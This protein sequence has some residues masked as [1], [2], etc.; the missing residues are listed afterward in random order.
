MKVYR[1]SRLPID[2]FDPLDASASVRRGGWRWNERDTALLYAGS[3]QALAILEVAA[4]PGWDQIRELVIAEIEVPDGSVVDLDTLG[5]VLPSN[6]SNRPAAPNAKRIGT[7]FL[8]AVGQATAAGQDLCG[9]RVPSVIS[10]T[11]FTVILDPQQCDRYRVSNRFVLA[12][13]WLAG[14]ST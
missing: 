3:V 2:Q 4:R 5:I 11:D 1:A 14:T 6:W 10:S 7:A 9:L 13:D 12:F 8:Q